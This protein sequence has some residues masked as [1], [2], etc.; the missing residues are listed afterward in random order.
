MG[1]GRDGPPEPFRRV[2]KTFLAS[3]LRLKRWHVL[4]GLNHTSF[5]A[6]V[7]PRVKQLKGKELGALYVG[8]IGAGKDE[9][10]G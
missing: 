3:T 10:Y 6:D 8:Y 2:E 5:E 9:G 7:A 1:V 4:S